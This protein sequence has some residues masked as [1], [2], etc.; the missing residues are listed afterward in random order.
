MPPI[1]GLDFGN[2][3][4]YA[5]FISDFDTG[6]RI[7]G[8][9]RD[10][11]PPRLPDGIPS[12][13]FYSKRVGPLLGEN[14][15]KSRAVPLENRLRYLKRHLGET[16]TLDDREISY[17]DAITQVIQHCVRVANSQLEKGWL[18]TTNLLSL[19]YPATYTFAQ[20]QRLVELA[21]RATLEDG[22]KLSVFGTIAEPAAAALDYLSEYAK[23]DQETTVLTYDLGGGTFDLALVTVY[24]KGKTNAAGHTYYYDIISTRGLPSVGG[25]EFDGVLYRLLRSKLAPGTWESM[26]ENERWALWN[27][28]EPTKVELSASD[29]AFPQLLID[30]DYLD[31]S[32]T[33]TEFEAASKELLMQ[34]V[35]A[36]KEILQDHANQKPKV[37][38]LTGGA[39]QMPMVQETLKRELPEY[40]DKIVYFRPSRA[41]AYGAARYGTSESNEDPAAAGTGIIQQRVMYDLGVRF[42]HDSDD[43]KVFVGKYIQA[44]AEIPLEGEFHGARTAYE[45]LCTT[46]FCV[47]EAKKAHPD[48]EKPD[49]DWQEIMSVTVDFGE[50]VPKGTTSEF[51]LDVDKRGIISIEA[52]RTDIP[53]APLVKNHIQLKNLS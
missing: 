7:G 16:T 18:E 30:G 53:D 37:I 20:R 1:I 28:V 23:E 11:L 40:R 19:A 43:K 25:S 3:N 50:H 26:S 14:A 6:T 36:T 34:T 49:E 47:V 9:V 41:I 38:L 21:E 51:R 24:P 12:I 44:G 42:L 5:C 46:C 22:R 31:V 15:A 33:R 35:L 10:L 39:S 13:Y 2:F 48:A 52:R 45:N 17:D 32:V 4:T 27:L 29:E 8:V